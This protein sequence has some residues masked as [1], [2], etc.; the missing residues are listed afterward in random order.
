MISCQVFIYPEAECAAGPPDPLLISSI[1]VADKCR[2]HC[3]QLQTVIESIL[4][5]VRVCLLLVFSSGTNHYSWIA[6]GK[7]EGPFSRFLKGKYK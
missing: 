3:L 5:E 4:T 1:F 6:I 2:C 7:D